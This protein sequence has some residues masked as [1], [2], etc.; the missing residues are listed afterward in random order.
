MI[1]I[2]PIETEGQHY[3]EVIM[4]GLPLQ[5]RGPF[6]DP[7]EAAIVAARMTSVCRILHAEVAVTAPGLRRSR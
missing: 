3:V 1:D 7:N 5:P 6:Q 4:D 2:R